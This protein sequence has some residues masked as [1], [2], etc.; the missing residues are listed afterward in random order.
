MTEKEEK[1]I[2]E[3]SSTLTDPEKNLLVKQAQDLISRQNST[4]D[5]NALPSIQL[6]DIPKN[7]EKIL[8]FSSPSLDT[9]IHE[10]SN[11]NF[12]ENSTEFFWNSQPTNGLSY[13]RGMIFLR[14]VS[15]DL[16]PYVPLLCS[17]LTH[18][19]TLKK[20]YREIS[21]EMEL[22]TGGI[23]ISSGI[24]VDPDSNHKKKKKIATI[25][26]NFFFFFFFYEW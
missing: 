15:P 2:Q 14:K 1:K 16:I 18:I 4:P 9:P 21:Q 19:G 3:I 12:L 5:L 8:L 6:R 20:S 25:G 13:L 10:N 23:N 26:K 24:R 11:K 22:F 7:S 17:L